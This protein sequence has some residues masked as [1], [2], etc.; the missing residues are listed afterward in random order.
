MSAADGPTARAVRIAVRAVPAS[1]WAV[2][3]ATH[4]VGALVAVDAPPLLRVPAVL[5]WTLFA[6]GHPWARLLHLRD[7]GDALTAALAVSLAAAAVVAGLLALAGAWHA[8]TAFGL[9][10]VLAAAGVLA[11]AVRAGA[12]APRPVPVPVAVPGGDPR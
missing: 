10:A 2:L 1:G 12:S 6:P 11:P 5:A 8:P 7:R 9:L 3:V 4:L